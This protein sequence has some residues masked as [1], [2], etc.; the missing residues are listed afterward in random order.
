M[1][2]FAQMYLNGMK[3]L[4]LLFLCFFVKNVSAQDTLYHAVPMLGHEKFV[5]HDDGTFFYSSHL[6]GYTYLSFGS[7][8]KNCFG[9]S[10]KNDTTKCLQPSLVSSNEGIT[11]DCIVLHFYNVTDSLRVSYSGLVLIGDHIFEC[12]SDSLIIP[13]KPIRSNTLILN[14]EDYSKDLTF[15]FDSTSTQLNLYLNLAFYQCGIN[16][17]RKLKKTKYGYLNKVIVY[18]EIRDKPWKKGKKRVVKH[19]YELRT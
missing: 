19:Y 5:L 14:S 9:Y 4:L 15:T 12:Q 7:Y 13:K 3:Q 16:G 11:S 6:C 1:E 10:F 18:D 17:T 8:R 2:F